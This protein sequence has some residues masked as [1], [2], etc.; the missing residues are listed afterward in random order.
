MKKFPILENFPF[1]F[2]KEVSRSS[3]SL[4]AKLR[5]SIELRCTG[6][7]LFYVFQ[8]TFFWPIF[9]LVPPCCLLTNYPY[10]LLKCFHANGESD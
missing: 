8:R 9:E 3:N 7:R 5:K 10:L 1:I 2:F 6:S 4:F